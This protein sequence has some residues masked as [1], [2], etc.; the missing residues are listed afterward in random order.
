MRT[1]HL[2][3]VMVALSATGILLAGCSTQDGPGG[4]MGGT[5]A[6]AG[7]GTGGTVGG[8]GGMMGPG[9]TA[10]PLSCTP[11]QGLPGSRV[12]VTLGD[13]GMSQMMGGTAP[14][15]ARMMLVAEPASVPAGQVSFVVENRGWRTHELVV[16]PLAAG[17]SA[18]ELVPG[19]DGKVDETGGLGEASSTCAAGPGE[20][21]ESGSAGWVTLTL[22]PGRYELVCNLT[23]HYA[24][25]MY[26]ELVV[27]T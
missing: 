11:P 19:S 16:L 15:G 24:N 14:M 12:D 27:T 8:Q 10:A 3:T 21:I 7:G 1:A 25:G 23:N 6:N 26:D 20:G 22:T 9:Y 5:S 17:T 2:A 13:M 4:M 18:G